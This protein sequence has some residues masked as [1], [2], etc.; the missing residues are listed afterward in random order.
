[1]QGS[2][3]NTF[4]VGARVLVFKKDGGK[5]TAEN[6]PVRGFQ[7]SAQIPLHVG[8]GSA[9]EV[10]SVLVVWPD[11][12]YETLPNP[13]FNQVQKFEWKP[14]LPDFDFSKMKTK[15][16]KFID[17]QDITSQTGIDFSHKENDF[18]EFNR[19]LLIPNMVSSEGPA[20][21]VGDVNG[22]GLDDVLFG[23]S[24]KKRSALYLQN[25]GGKF[26]LNTSAA[27][28]RDSVF[29]DVDAVFADID[30]DG[31]LDLAIAAGGNE[32][33]GQDEAMRQRI[34]LNDGKGNFDE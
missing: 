2:E 1:L 13:V 16:A 22:D 10:D 15:P 19:E 30:E 24:K 14:N 4:A 27:I 11:R 23:S 18:V 33:R 32:F 26:S 5:I 34:Y 12:T 31:D 6:F 21:A 8:V 28:I 9:S 29:E 25:A 20:L 17:F 7:S 3:K